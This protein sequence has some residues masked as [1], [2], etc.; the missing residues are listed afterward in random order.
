MK[1]GT[2]QFKDVELAF[3]FKKVPACDQE[4]LRTMFYQTIGDRSVKHTGISFN[5][6]YPDAGSFTLFDNEGDMFVHMSEYV[7]PSRFTTSH[8]LHGKKYFLAWTYD[9]DKANELVTI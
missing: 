3:N 6:F 7:N 5:E 4:Y 1:K 9:Q 8:L 2:Y